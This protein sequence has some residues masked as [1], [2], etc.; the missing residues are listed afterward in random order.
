MAKRPDSFSPLRR[1]R[2]GNPGIRA[3]NKEVCDEDSG[4]V[5]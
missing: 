1:K 4:K 3:N 5:E 2:D